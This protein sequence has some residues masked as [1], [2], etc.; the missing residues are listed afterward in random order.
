[1]GQ[2]DEQRQFDRLLEMLLL[3]Q[4]NRRDQDAVKAYRLHVCIV[5]GSGVK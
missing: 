1:M 4:L 2:A 3:R 5:L